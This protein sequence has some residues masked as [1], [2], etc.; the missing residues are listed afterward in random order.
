MAKLVSL[1]RTFIAKSACCQ[2]VKGTIGEEIVYIAW[3]LKFGSFREF[4]LN[5]QII[6]DHQ[7]FVRHLSHL[8]KPSLTYAAY[9][10]IVMILKFQYTG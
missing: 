5:L 2:S 8:R 9:I 1:Q 10:F 4:C 7:L 6:L 3:Q